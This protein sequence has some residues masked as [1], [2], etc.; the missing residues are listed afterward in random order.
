MP[1]GNQNTKC[2]VVTKTGVK[3]LKLKCIERARSLRG[4]CIKIP[5]ISL[6]SPLQMEKMGWR[7]GC[8][9]IQSLVLP[10]YQVI[11]HISETGG[12]HALLLLLSSHSV[13]AEV[14][15]FLDRESN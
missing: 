11:N 4:Q 15:A 14:Q 10:S 3:S 13:D 7:Q 1:V 9:S 12:V 5:K 8:Q 2:L 6:Q